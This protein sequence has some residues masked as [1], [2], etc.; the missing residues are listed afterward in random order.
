QASA[1]RCR[2]NRT[3]PARQ[4]TCPRIFKLARP[5][6]PHQRARAPFLY[7]RATAAPALRRV[8]RVCARD[9]R[10]VRDDATRRSDD[11]RAQAISASPDA[12]SQSVSEIAVARRGDA[13]TAGGSDLRFNYV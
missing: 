7:L 10:V 5:R 6:T 4:T 13:S 1:A 12:R 11:T 9:E 2:Q 3:T 8:G